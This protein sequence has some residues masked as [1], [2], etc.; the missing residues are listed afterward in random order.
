MQHMPEILNTKSANT[1]V[2]ALREAIRVAW[3]NQYLNALQKHLESAKELNTH[4]GLLDEEIKI[5]Q[6]EIQHAFLK[7]TTG[8]AGRAQGFYY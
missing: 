2:Q 7:E 4:E 3:L 5:C 8:E 6:D 1:G